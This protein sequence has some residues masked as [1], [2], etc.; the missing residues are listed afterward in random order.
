M[1]EAKPGVPGGKKLSRKQ[2][3]AELRRVL[4]QLLR[5]WRME[6]WQIEVCRTTV[7]GEARGGRELGR[8]E[9]DVEHRS[10]TIYLAPTGNVPEPFVLAHEMVHL[11]L[12]G[13]Y[14][15]FCDA[16]KV[17]SQDRREVLEERFVQEQ[18]Q[19]CNTLAGTVV[20]MRPSQRLW[21][22]EE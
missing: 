9:W 4:R 14:E 6:D 20:S 18:E 3:D 5:E 11:L 8:V 21:H 15:V 10:A 12:H 19:V 17:L 16:T 22:Q 2:A 1:S 7:A 13:M